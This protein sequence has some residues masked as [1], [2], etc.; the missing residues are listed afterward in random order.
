VN[1]QGQ[2]LPQNASPLM[3][4]VPNTTDTFSDNHQSCSTMGPMVKG[5]AVTIIALMILRQH[6]VDSSHP[7]VLGTKGKGAFEFQDQVD[8]Y[9]RYQGHVDC[10]ERVLKIF[11]DAS[12]TIAQWRRTQDLTNLGYPSLPLVSRTEG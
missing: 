4:A 11:G 5:I 8:Q 10:A 3:V 2:H 12:V 6:L 7:S 1:P 9:R